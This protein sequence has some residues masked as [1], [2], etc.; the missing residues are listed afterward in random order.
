[1]SILNTKNIYFYL[2]LIKI[3]LHFRFWSTV[4]FNKE[5]TVGLKTFLQEAAPPHLLDQLPK[6]D[7]VLNIYREI[8]Y[9]AFILFK[10]LTTS[11]ENEVLLFTIFLNS[12]IFYYFF[13]KIICRLITCGICYITTM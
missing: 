5:A 11:S 12:L 13:R 6:D 3:F 7:D 9:F 4:I 10:R 8:D 1:M 2:I